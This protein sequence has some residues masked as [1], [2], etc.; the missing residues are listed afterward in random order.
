MKKILLVIMMLLLITGSV[1]ADDGDQ[2]EIE[3][4]FEKGLILSIEEHESDNTFVTK[5]QVAQVEIL[6]GKFKGQIV[7]VENM[8]SDSFVSDIEIEVGQKVLLAVEEYSDGTNAFYI[9][10]EVRDNFI[11]YLLLIFIAALLIVGKLQGLKT[12]FT[13]GVTIFFIFF[14]ELPLLIK[15][16][17]A[18]LVTVVVAIFITIITVTVISGLSKKSLAAIL[19]TTVGVVIAGSLAIFVSIQVNIT[20]MSMEESVMLLTVYGEGLNFQN[21]LFASILIG[22]LGAIMDVAM[23]IASSIDELHNVNGRLTSKEL[24]DSGM[25]VGRD[26][27]GTMANTLILAYTGSSLALILLFMSVNDSILRTMNLDVIAT[28]IIRSLAGSIGL[29]ATIPITALIAVYLIKDKK[30][31]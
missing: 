27:M 4:S 31:E 24:F 30:F 20:G 12:I 13:L 11:I 3:R 28:E 19:G 26:I 22:A 1:I 29:V 2:D 21:L 17:N 15:G 14:I 8:L 7:T 6:T 16:H 18:I 10:S 9:Q 5:V 25:R 23:S